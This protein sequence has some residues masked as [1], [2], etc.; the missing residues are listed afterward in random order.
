MRKRNTNSFAILLAAIMALSIGS[1]IMMPSRALAASSPE[2]TL[3]PPAAPPGTPIMVNGTGFQSGATV[4]L[5]WFGYIVDVPG[6]S[7]HIGYYPIKTGVTVE[8]DGSFQTTI[9][10]PYDFSDTIHFVNATQNG[11]G[12]G[13]TDATF[14]IAPTLSLSSEPANYTDGQQ[15]F[16]TVYG[17]PLGTAAFAMGLNPQNETMVLKLT[18]DNAMWGFVTSHLETE[19]PVVTAGFTGGDIGGNATIRFN[20][21]GEVGQH[22]IRGYVGAKDTSPYL[23]CEIGGQ[24]VFTIVGP[25]LDAESILSKLNSLDTQILSVQGDTA[26]I[27][28]GVGNVTTSLSNID[29]KITSLQGSVAIVSTDVGTLSGNITSVSN[30]VA[31]IQTSL[32]NLTVSDT[33][34]K[35]SSDTTGSYTLVLLVLVLIELIVLAVVA[36]RVYRK[37]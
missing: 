4:D 18:Y 11:Q 8:P 21:V 27:E 12:T 24:A 36:T 20:A 16:L 25:G 22:I 34:V 2:I 23:P 31:T 14:T 10:T 35:N 26:I 15:V 19:G 32:G 28:T 6:I 3:L 37:S 29:A 30:G 17:A 9:I 13:I 33:A 7:G 5:S 1:F